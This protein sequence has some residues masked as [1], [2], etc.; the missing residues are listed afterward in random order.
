MQKEIKPIEYEKI[1]TSAVNEVYNNF[2]NNVEKDFVVPKIMKELFSNLKNITNKEDLDTFG[3]TFD[4]S[5]SEWKSE[6]ENS[7]KL[8]LLNHMMAIFQNAVVVILSL[9]N[10]LEKEKLEKGIVKEMG[11]LDIIVTTTLQAFGTKSN[12]LIEAYQNRYEIDKELNIFENINNTL[13]RIV[14]IPADQAFRDL[15]QNLIDFFESYFLGYKKLSETKSINWTKEKFDMLMDYA[16]AFY[17]LAFFTRLVLTYP[18]QEGLMPEEVFNKIVPTI[19]V[20]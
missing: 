13:K 17:L 6:N 5:L 2:L 20:Y 11:G 14:D 18:K 7:D 12:E 10:N 1:I 9:D 19:N 3:I 16:N 15:V 8:V 4:K